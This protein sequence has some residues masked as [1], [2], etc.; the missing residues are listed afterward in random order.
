M[1]FARMTQHKELAIQHKQE[2]SN[3]K[4]ACNK[5]QTKK[6]NLLYHSEL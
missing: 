6:T 3:N 2:I 5:K 1:V 4:Q